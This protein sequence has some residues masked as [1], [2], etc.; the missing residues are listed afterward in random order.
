VTLGAV[1]FV[2]GGARR[3]SVVLTRRYRP[4][5]TEVTF[6]VN[7]IWSPDGRTVA[8]TDLTN[9][10]LQILVRGIDAIRSTLVTR[11]SAA[12]GLPPF[13]SPDGSRLY[14]TRAGD[15]NLV[16]V[17]VGGGEPQ[18]VATAVEPGTE[19]RPSGQFGGIRACISPDW[20]TIVFTRGQEG[21]V[22][23]WTLDT[24]TNETRPVDRAGMPRP[25]LYV[26]A[27]AFSPDGSMLGMLASTTALN[28]SRGIWLIGHDG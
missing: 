7:P 18:L 22:R 1:G 12:T 19:G 6:A 3:S 9:G 13:W 25:L 14:F 24:R 16:S 28:Q 2:A 20:R 26:Q 23:L 5:I 17:G 4:F 8:Y 11:E 15:G 27:L 10:H 21:G